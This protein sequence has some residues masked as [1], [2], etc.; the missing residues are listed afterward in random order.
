MGI[1]AT[2]PLVYKFFNNCLAE[3]GAWHVTFTGPAERVVD[4]PLGETVT[5]ELPPGQYTVFYA[6]DNGAED[7]PFGFFSDDGPVNE[8]MCPET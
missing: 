3:F 5:G 6:A 2:T 8:E 1:G 4:I 7:G